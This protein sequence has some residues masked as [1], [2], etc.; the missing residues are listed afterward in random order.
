MIDLLYFLGDLLWGFVGLFREAT[1]HR[2]KRYRLVGLVCLVS[3]VVVWGIAGFIPE[4]WRLVLFLVGVALFTA[5]VFCGYM[6]LGESGERRNK[7]G[8]GELSDAAEQP[9]D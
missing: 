9:R 2:A 6:R 3:W 7:R 1:T 4:T 5:C 8:K